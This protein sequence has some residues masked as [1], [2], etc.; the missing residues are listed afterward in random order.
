[1]EEQP[2]HHHHHHYYYYGHHHHHHHHPP[3]SAYL[4]PPDGRAQPKPPLRH[5]H[6]HQDTPKRR[7]GYGE[8]N[9]NAGEREVSLKGLCSDETT[10]PGSRVPNGSQQLV[11]TNVTPKQT[12]KAG[13]LGK[14]GI[15]PKNFIQKNSMDKKNEKSYEN[16]LRESQPS[17]K[18][19]GVSIP[20]GVVT[21]NSSY[22]TNGYVGKGADN[23]GSG[24]ESGYTTPKK[25]KGRRNSAKG[26]ENLNL[27]QDK[28]MQ[29]E[30]S[31]PT[32]K[33]ELES[34]KSDYS[35]QK[36][37]R[38]EN[39]KPVWKYEAGAGGAGRGKPGLGD[40]QR[41]NSDAKPGIS[42]KKFD[43]RPKG[44][45]ASSAT[46]KEDSWTLFKP[47]PVFPVDNSSA[48]IVPKI[49]YASK[50]KENL[51]KAAQT[52]STS[53]SSSSSS[54]GE[55]QA[56]TSSRLSQVPMSAMKSVTSASFSNGP[57]LAGTDGSVYSP[58][59][60][61]LL[62][63]AASTVPSTSSESVAQDMSTTS[64][65]LEQKKSSLFIYPSNMQTVLLGTAQVD[66]PSQTNQ[67]NLGDIFQNQWGLS[68][69][70]EPSAGPET[71][72]GK[73]ADNQLMEVTFQGEYPA[74]LVSQC[75]EIIPSGTEQ[76][77]FPKAYELDKR[78]SPQILSAIL[79]PGTAVE[80]GVLAL[81]S[82]HTGDLQ[83]ADTGSQGALV[84]LSKDYEIENPLASPTNNLLASAK[85]QRYQRGLERKDSWGSFDLRAAIIYHTKEMESVWNLQKQDPKRIITYDEA[86]DRPD[87]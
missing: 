48:K 16:K 71:V 46:S 73:S 23:D 69:I 7:T 87:Q 8:L 83:K 26:C 37:N 72:V 25:R 38:I 77:V 56:Q 24:S 1:M 76:P 43:D 33:Q 10:T 86:M 70:N 20:N 13:A 42:S 68:F 78:T 12:V 66:F 36:G 75:A 80:G 49:S 2:H 40:V 41:K 9:G 50:V 61:P 65:T 57:I 64:T 81:E 63:T 19:E 85:E 31:A 54:A 22:I 79:K 44:K 21:N 17:D 28:I 11:D 29:Q 15:K 74:T 39:T 62:S 53:S 59:T 67:Q 82:H 52:P 32:L 5:E 58:G 34:F 3:Q 6:K 30:V 60:Q 84:F 27:V 45:H 14:A 51:N 47:P 4:P 18:P 55:T 35:E